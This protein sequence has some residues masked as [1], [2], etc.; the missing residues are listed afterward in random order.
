MQSKSLLIAIAAFAVTT[1]GAQAYGGAILERANISDDQRSALEQAHELR[2]GGEIEAARDVLVEAGIDEEVLHELRQAARET[3]SEIKLAV[4]A[5]DYDLF[6]ELIVDTSLADIIT[7][8]ADFALFKEAQELRQSGDYEDARVIFDELGIDKS[9]Y[10]HQLLK[11]H[12]AHQLTDEQKE[13]LL[14]AKQA[15]DREAVKAILE[16]AGIERR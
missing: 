11:R 1:T 5:G 6:R 3:R 14:V 13:A 15:N 9:K 8:E 16:E 12:I 4:E 7:S 2:K 10:G